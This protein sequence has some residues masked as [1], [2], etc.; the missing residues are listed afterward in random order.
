MKRWWI[1][2]LLCLVL[3]TSTL[4]LSTYAEAGNTE[5]KGYEAAKVKEVTPSVTLT[6]KTVTWTGKERKPSVTVRAGSRTLAA[7]RDYKVVYKDNIN[8]GKAR[9]KVTL[10]G[11]YS[12]SKTVSFAI[13]P[14]G[15]QISSTNAGTDTAAV[16]W[17][18]QTAKMSAKRITGYQV[19]IAADKQFTKDKKTATVN[20]YQKTAK[21]FTKLKSGKK[22][23]FRVRTFTRVGEKNY[24]SAWSKVRAQQTKKPEPEQP[25][26]KEIVYRPYDVKLTDLL[27]EDQ[28]AN[29]IVS[30]MSIHLALAM[31]LEGAEGD[32]KE[33]LENFLGVKQEGLDAYI[34]DI[35]LS[36][37]D[38]EDLKMILSNAFWYRIGQ[39]VSGEYLNTLRE[40]YAAEIS[41]LDFLD[42]ENAAKVIND[43]CREKTNGLIPKIVSEADVTDMTDVFLNTL[44]F[45]ASWMEPVE[46]GSLKKAKF[47]GLTDTSDAV[48]LQ[49]HEAAAYENDKAVAF[50]R[51]Y[52]GKYAFIGILPKKEG[53][54]SLEE[55]DL[56]GLLQKKTTD[57]DEI[58]VMMPKFTAESGGD[59][60]G[61]LQ[62]LGI[63]AA[64]TPEAEFAGIAPDL[65]ISK[66]IHK[67]KMTLDEN[68]TEAAAATAVIGKATAIFTEK[69]LEIKLNRPFAFLIIDTQTGNILFMGK[70]TDL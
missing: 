21:K 56:P 23:Y 13:R 25:A 70:I 6:R 35:L 52:E 22:Y 30:P 28:K 34:K 20:G 69:I 60:T 7:G 61:I 64:F 42:G 32:T 14:K 51:P 63:T 12:G 19:Q 36:A 66:V 29:T 43:W 41:D 62:K 38:T 1:S 26:A 67:T 17:E 33:E 59:I 40:R 57:Y 10:K 8:V 2:F 18:R 11:K 68:G 54:F 9:V 65:M 44:Y 24:F 48:Y 31:L 45:K 27:Y 16:R 58:H 4:S 46:E 37:K 39:D 15:T 55:L 49:S 3:C 53:A 5:I 47:N 50:E